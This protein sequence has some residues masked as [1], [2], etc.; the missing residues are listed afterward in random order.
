[1]VKAVDIHKEIAKKTFLHG[2]GEATESQVSMAEQKGTTSA[3]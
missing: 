2:R 1:M 3:V